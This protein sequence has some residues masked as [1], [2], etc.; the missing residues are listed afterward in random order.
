[1]TIFT[2]KRR[3]TRTKK[4]VA[5]ERWTKDIKLSFPYGATLRPA[6]YSAYSRY[7]SRA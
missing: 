6:P 4:V 5:P 3:L 2:L 7:S 1:M